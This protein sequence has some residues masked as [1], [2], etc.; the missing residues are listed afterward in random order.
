MNR[1]HEE[2]MRREFAERAELD[3]SAYRSGVTEEQM[4]QIYSKS[5]EY[6]KRWLNGPHAEHWQF[7]DD[8]YH[9][10]KDN[11]QAMERMRADIA[12]N[13]QQGNEIGLTDVQLRSMDQSRTLIQQWQQRQQA[14]RAQRPVRER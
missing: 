11:P 1:E 3:Q 10:W 9:D 7:L 2:M 4:D 8:A 12:H 13:Q 6:D 5:C 14:E